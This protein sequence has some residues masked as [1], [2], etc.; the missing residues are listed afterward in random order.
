MLIIIFN[1]QFAL[2]VLVLYCTFV[3]ATICLGNL[4]ASC[5]CAQN[6]KRY[7]NTEI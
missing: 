6:K 5:V 3:T 1:N 2:I 4:D 7:I